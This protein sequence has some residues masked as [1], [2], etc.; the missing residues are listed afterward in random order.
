MIENNLTYQQRERIAHLVTDPVARRLPF[1]KTTV[2]NFLLSNIFT[3]SFNVEDNKFKYLL[4]IKYDGNDKDKSAFLKDLKKE[5]SKDQLI[6]KLYN[7]YILMLLAD[8][9]NLT[10]IQ[11]I[12]P[13]LKDSVPLNLT[14]IIKL[15][16]DKV[17][18]K[19]YDNRSSF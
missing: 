5:F 6:Y 12:C 3:A 19:I 15:S 16:V 4:S 18:G 2:F 9:A 13:S 1:S 7:G 11:L 17:Q 14:K 10:Y 8:K